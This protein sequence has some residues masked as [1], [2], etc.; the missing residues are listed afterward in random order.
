LNPSDPTRLSTDPGARGNGPEARRP[1][2]D[3]RRARRAELDAAGRD[4]YESLLRHLQAGR[5]LPITPRRSRRFLGGIEIHPVARRILAVSAIVVALILGAMLV[6]SRIRADQVDTWSGPDAS[7][8]SGIN[9]EGCDLSGYDD[10]GVF[11]GWIRFGGA[12]YRWAD[13]SAPISTGSI[14]TR[15][16]ATDDRLGDLRL[17]RI[18]SSGSTPDAERILVRNGDADAGGVYLLVPSCH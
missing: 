8:Q 9:L 18:V 16:Q 5:E 17:F 12:I 6:T 1:S 15:Y 2:I 11:P 10:N 14:G 3:E 4:R 7:V 13:L